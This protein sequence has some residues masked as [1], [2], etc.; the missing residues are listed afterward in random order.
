MNILEAI[1][2]PSVSLDPHQIRGQSYDGASVMSSE[3]A[4]V[5]AKIKEVSPRALYIYPLLFHCLN[6]T[7]AASC[8]VQEV[9]NL[10]SSYQ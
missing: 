9:R 5:Q 4:G 6:L 7:I 2:D 1:S 10:I 3:I 8:S